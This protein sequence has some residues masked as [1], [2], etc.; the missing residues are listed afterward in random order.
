MDKKAET[1]YNLGGPLDDSFIEFLLSNIVIPES[2]SRQNV[3]PDEV[4]TVRSITLGLSGPKVPGVTAFTKCFPW[5][6]L[7]LSSWFLQTCPNAIYFTSIQ[8]NEGFACNRHRDRGNRGLSAIRA[9]GDF[10]GGEVLF[11]RDDTRST[12]VEGLRIEDATT[13]DVR[14]WQIFDGTKA[15][16][17]LQF[18]GKR[19]SAVFYVSCSLDQ[20]SAETVEELE[21]LGA[22]LP[23]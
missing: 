21:W 19:V 18:S 22:N 17:T 4:E 3:I 23:R 1:R 5:I 6:F 12:G 10:V 11:W 8:L 7:V 15:H 16:E 14:D 20:A 13:L 2:A 9:V